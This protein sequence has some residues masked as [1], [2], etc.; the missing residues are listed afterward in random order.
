MTNIAYSLLEFHCYKSSK[1][2]DGISHKK[3]KTSILSQLN[4]IRTHERKKLLD[5]T[6]EILKTRA[7]SEK[8]PYQEGLINNL[9]GFAVETGHDL[10]YGRALENYNKLSNLF[11]RL[12][13][14]KN[15][16]DL[17]PGPFHDF[18]EEAT[19]KIKTFIPEQPVF[20]PLAPFLF[21][22][23][24]SFT[25]GGISVIVLNE[26]GAGHLANLFDAFVKFNTYKDFAIILIDRAST[27][28]SLVIAKSYLD[29]LP[30]RI[31]RQDQKFTASY[32]YNL[33]VDACDSE[34]LLFLDNNLA[35][36]D[37][38]LPLL[39]NIYKN[40][41]APGIIGASISRSGH[42]E[43]RENNDLFGGIKFT[44]S[45]CKGL[46]DIPYPTINHSL[47][48]RS[49]LE[50]SVPYYR[51]DEAEYVPPGLSLPCLK[52][53]PVKHALKSG[54]ETV[55]ALQGNAM[56]CSR[57]DFIRTGGFDLN[58]MDGMQAVDLSLSFKHH[59]DKEIL[60]AHD[61]LL[62]MN[63]EVNSGIPPKKEDETLSNFN[64]G[65]LINRHGCYIKSSYYADLSSQKQT[66]TDDR[67]SAIPGAIKNNK[68]RI[69]IKTPAFDDE[70]TQLWGDYHFAHS[71]KDAFTRKG[72]DA[73][74]DLHNYWY[75]HGY[76]TDDVV[77]VLRGTKR[78]HTRG[79]QVNILWNISHPELLHEDEYRDYDHVFS[80]S[81]SYADKLREKYGIRA[82]NLLQ[83]TDAGLFYP[84]QENVGDHEKTGI[85]FV[86]NSREVMRKSVAYS[87]LKGFPLDVYGS[88]WEQFLPAGMIKGNYIQNEELRKYYSN[89]KIL[90]NDHWQDMVES[91]FIS[92]RIF[93]ALACGA[94]VLTDRV[95]GI[96]KVFSKGI[97]YYDDV[98]EFEERIKWLMENL[99]EARILALENSRD[100]LRNHTF[101]NRAERILEVIMNIYRQKTTNEN[102]GHHTGL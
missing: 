86:G 14:L 3:M 10:N 70:R 20:R 34:F 51:K 4:I 58:Y 29:K 41:R 62:V 24:N 61:V 54:T 35:F 82:E 38:I 15:Q 69:A 50:K 12:F 11:V 64:L 27:D 47:L 75:D 52:P 99:E 7:D 28:N 22:N 45:E 88:R 95:K 25:N 81:T 73:R 33:A 65:V 72:F 19:G 101:D 91:G 9:A 1:L 76:M 36:S 55:A 42:E 30:V 74:V 46:P 31:I 43:L 49:S 90:L 96:E 63:D 59:L 23:K 92:N 83:C 18:L 68:L 32:L 53:V 6:L 26:N 44:L 100:V 85:L 77:I 93:D 84:D 21:L 102:I 87:I 89:C 40:S 67:V 97:F 5:K 17:P 16:E 94:I 78:Y 66:W 60:L 98:D 57:A 39:L 79:S 56:F 8:Q 2:P 80:A 48:T 37:D 71:L 13:K